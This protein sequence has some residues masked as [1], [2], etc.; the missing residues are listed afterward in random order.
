MGYVDGSISC[1]LKTLSVIDGA[2]VAKGSPNYPIWV[3]YDAYVRMLII[4]TIS[5]AFFRHVQGNNKGTI[6]NII[7]QLGSAFALKD[8]GPLNYFLGF[9]IVLHVSGIL[10]SQKKYI[11]K[12]L[13]SAGNPDTYLEAFSYADWAG[14]SDDRRST[15]RF[16]IYLALLNELGIRS[17][18]TPI[19]LC[20]NVGAT[21][22]SANLIFHARTK[23]VEI[24]YHFVW[25]KV[26]QGDLRVQ[27]ISTH[28]Q[29]ADIFTKPLPTPRFLFLRS[30]LQVVA[31]P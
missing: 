4:S 25:E 3:S 13:Q 26:A 29:I 30:K 1:P 2:T 19:L 10:I 12:L 18:S 27:Y 5:E 9:E 23:H 11:L 17:S 16:A 6:D 28:D 20:D 8:L 22:L 15:R 7:C 24:Y 31:R 21:Y 14:D